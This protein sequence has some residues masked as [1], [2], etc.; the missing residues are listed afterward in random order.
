MHVR[1]KDMTYIAH[2]P[3]GTDEVLLSVPKYDFN[4]QIYLRAEG[5]RSVLPKGTIVEV[6]AHFDNSA[7]NKFNPGSVEGRQVGR[8]DVR[9]ND[10]RLLVDCQSRCR[11]RRR[12]RAEVGSLKSEV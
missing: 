2:Y 1:G 7:A 3:D 4:W 10:D 11:S 8:S 6:I 12:S 9:R 5:R